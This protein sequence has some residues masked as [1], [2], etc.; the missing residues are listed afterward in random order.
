MDASA[1]PQ[2]LDFYG[3]LERM[4]RPA[5]ADLVR[6][7]KSFIVSFTYQ[8]TDAENDS[9]KIQ[10]FL[11]TMETTIKGHPLWAHAADEEIDCAIEGL[12]KF[13]M[14]KLF[15]RT[16]ASSAEDAKADMDIFEKIRLLQ[17]FVKPD[18][19][20]VP[21]IIQNEAS[22]L[23]AAK[24]LQKINSFR[25]PREKL[26]CIMNCC[27]VINNLLLN[28]SMSMN[29]TPAGADEF[30]PILIYVTIKANPPQLHSNLKFVQFFRRQT[31][32]VS[33]VEYYLTNLISAKTFITN[34]NAS[35]L[36]MEE[37]EYQKNM[38]AAKL[39]SEV[40]VAV[41][42]N[43]L[44]S[45]KDHAPAISRHG[46]EIHTG[47]SRYPYMEENVRNLTPEDVKKLLG[48]YKQIVTRYTLLSEALRRLSIDE[49][50]L[51]YSVRDLQAEI[52]RK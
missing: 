49:D 7:V 23:F 11:M 24:E 30:L 43:T 3:F 4:R 13:V 39:A 42:S 15:N 51:L 35:S 6:A 5:A 41:P 33:E 32:L 25:S 18:H 16:F 12:E 50:Q 21:V 2:N 37:S 8:A 28:V 19:L 34:L 36:S 40:A 9:K 44:G 22:W 27:Q 14:T 20:D 48:L 26:L 38:Q 46:K 1:T 45:S 17:H 10:E 31:K 52:E 47:G 29:R